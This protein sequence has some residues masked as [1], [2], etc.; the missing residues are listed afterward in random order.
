VVL[1]QTATATARVN[2]ANQIQPVVITLKRNQVARTR[3]RYGH[4]QYA[5]SNCGDQKYRFAGRPFQNFIGLLIAVIAIYWAAWKFTE[6]RSSSS[7]VM[8]SKYRAF[9]LVRIKRCLSK[10][11]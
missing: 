8:L 2:E 5:F 9:A 10:Q 4:Q 1:D 7:S 6:H 11:Y 3:G